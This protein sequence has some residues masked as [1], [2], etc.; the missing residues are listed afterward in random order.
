[1]S[2]V[3]IN[4]N[5]LKEIEEYKRIGIT[6]F[7]FP[8]AKLSIGYKDYPLDEIP[9]DSYLLINRVLEHHD[10]V[11]VKSIKKEL[12]KYRGIIFEDLGIYE[13]FKN[14]NIELIWNQN[15]FATNKSSINYYLE[16]GC[17]SVVISNEITKEEI[18]TIVNEAVKPIILTVFA[19]NQIMYSR[20]TLLTNFNKY[21]GLSSYNDVNI[22]PNEKNNFFIR[23]SIYGTIIYND[24]YFNYVDLMKKVDDTHIKFY[25]V[26]NLDKTPQEIDEILKGKQIGNDGFLNKKTVYKMSEYDD[27]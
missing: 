6:N 19:K 14:E 21:N 11:Y 2:K 24:E 22:V 20:R 16:H 5:D 27:R 9:K 18:Q 1:M 13:I 7:L 26:L 4:I 8:V 15:H 23:E 17:N 25:L 10:I 12:L 3:L